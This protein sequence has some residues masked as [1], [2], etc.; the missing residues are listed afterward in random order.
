MSS[1]TLPQLMPAYREEGPELVALR[2]SVRK[3]LDEDR[4]STGWRPACDSW[5]VGWD[6]SFSRRLGS[7]GFLGLDIPARYGGHES[8]P[9]HRYVVMEELLAAGAP[10][11][12]HWFAERQIAP[13][14]LHYGS[15]EQRLDFLPA[16]ARG[17]RYVGIGLSEPDAG[18]DLASVRTRAVETPD[19][20]SL[21][22]TKVWT[23]GA[24]HAHAF[25]VLARTDPP[26]PADRHAGLSQ[27]VVPLDAPGVQIRPID[28]LTGDHHFNEVVLDGVNLPHAAI[29]GERG[30]GWQQVTAELAFER[31]GPER[32]L[33]TYPLLDAVIGWQ[34]RR[35]GAAFEPAL[36]GLLSR[37]HALRQLAFA[38]AGALADGRVPDIPAALVKDIGTRFESDVIQVAR[39]VTSVIP[40]RDADEDL[41]RLLAQAVLQAPGF[42]IRGGTNEI[43]RGIVARGL[44][45]R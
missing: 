8:G 5:L 32:F 34:Q 17:E 24:Q 1:T 38:V 3:F 12:A 16:I 29:L 20:W 35:G 15:E 41:P 21:S 30:N 26:D 10:V 33:S 25:F 18:S 22:G 23:S 27:F 11:A 37:L 19:G 43:L 44:G 42:T 6:E 40:D 4:Q 31:A 2:R 45:Q 39:A 9:L 7:A 14:L 13:A 36:G 28:L